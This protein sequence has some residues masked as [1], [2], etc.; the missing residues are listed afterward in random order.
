MWKVAF[1]R[2]L[3]LSSF[4]NGI[5]DSS[6][7]IWFAWLMNDVLNSIKPFNLLTILMCNVTNFYQLIGDHCTLTSCMCQQIVLVHCLFAMQN[8]VR[9]L[10][11][12]LVNIM[13]RTVWMDQTTWRYLVYDFSFI[14]IVCNS[15]YEMFGMPQ[16][17]ELVL[18]VNI[19]RAHTN[20]VD[21][22]G[23]Y[24]EYPWWMVLI[25]LDIFDSE[26]EYQSIEH[27]THPFAFE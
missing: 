15:I 13:N 9:Y 19:I 2:S 21:E 22:F 18:Q 3:S 10:V 12:I 27:N 4:L 1:F 7:K 16:Q 26:S 23:C 11:N 8:D 25:L 5:F 20:D 6:V 24:I 14:A 17:W